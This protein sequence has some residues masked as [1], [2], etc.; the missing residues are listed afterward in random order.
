MNWRAAL[1]IDWSNPGLPL[2]GALHAGLLLSTLIAFAFTPK[3]EEAPEAIPVDVVD[4]SLP[5]SV[6]QGEKTAP[7]QKNEP[8]K[9]RAQRVAQQEELKPDNADAKRDVPVPPSR[10]PAPEPDLQAKAEAEKAEQLKQEQ[11]E[12]EA[13]AKAVQQEAKAK[14]EAAARKAEAEAEAI[15]K[16]KKEAEAKE[17]AEAD[18]KAKAEAKAKA[19]AAA[20]AK[21]EAEAKQKAEDAKKLAAL[22]EQAKKQAE[23]KPEAPQFNPNDIKKLLESKEKPQ[24]QAAAAAE[25]NRTAA[26]GAA[27]ATGARLNPSQRDQ[28]GAVLKEQLAQCWSP[29]AGLAGAENA[30]PIVKMQL[31]QSGELQGQPVLVNSSS[32]PAFRPMAE[33]AMRAIRRCSPFRIPPQFAPFFNDWKDW[34]ITFDA[35]EMLG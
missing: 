6:T 32:D 21:A 1:K 31:S 28:L 9:P 27:N 24:Q 19:D 18:A 20:K 25:V 7:P 17:K 22:A 34:S 16:A 8:P 33:S 10:P 13:K 11:A 14:A 26:L 23:K 15:E 5:H 35:R 4:L 2:S 12:A 29:P 30:K 3:F